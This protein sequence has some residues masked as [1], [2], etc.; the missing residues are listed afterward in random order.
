[1]TNV[2]KICQITNKSIFNGP[3]LTFPFTIKL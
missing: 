1:M 3:F 2:F